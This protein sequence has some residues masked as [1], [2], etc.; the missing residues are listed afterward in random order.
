MQNEPNSSTPP[1]HFTP[2]HGLR[3]TSPERQKMQNEPNFNHRATKKCKTNPISHRNSSHLAEN[4]SKIDNRSSQISPPFK[5]YE[6]MQN[7][8]NF[9]HRATSPEKREIKICKT[10]PISIRKKRRA[11]CP[12]TKTIVFAKI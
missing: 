4:Q 12:N 7:E 2:E 6:N 9:N 5:R 8:P 10:N 1:P 11:C 3:E